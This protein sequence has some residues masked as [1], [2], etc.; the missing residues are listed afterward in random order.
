[1]QSKQWLVLFGLKIKQISQKYILFSFDLKIFY[2]I[3]R[4]YSSSIT[5]GLYI[6]IG[7]FFVLVDFMWAHKAKVPKI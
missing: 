2:S 1:M 5:K 4:F 7:V 6:Y 3:A